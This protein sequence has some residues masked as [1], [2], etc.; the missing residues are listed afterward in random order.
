MSTPGRADNN[1]R[2]ADADAVRAIL[3]AAAEWLAGAGVRS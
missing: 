2:P 1:L 3:R